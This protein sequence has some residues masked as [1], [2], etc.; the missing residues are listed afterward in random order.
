MQ[1]QLTNQVSADI[2]G[3]QSQLSGH[4]GQQASEFPPTGGVATPQTPVIQTGV[5]SLFMNPG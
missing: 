3:G 1:R 4:I 5:S 2:T